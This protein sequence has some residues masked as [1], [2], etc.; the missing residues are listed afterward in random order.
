LHDVSL[1]HLKC[2]ADS[3][4]LLANDRQSVAFDSNKRLLPV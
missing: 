1:S 2:S 4:G 3:L